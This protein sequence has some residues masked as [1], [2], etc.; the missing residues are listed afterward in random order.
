MIKTKII[1]VKIYIHKV[2][3]KMS[4]ITHGIV[5]KYLEQVGGVLEIS[6]SRIE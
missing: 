2:E 5:N 3:K 4:S 1:E 6:E